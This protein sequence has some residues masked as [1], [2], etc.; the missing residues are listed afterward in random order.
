MTELFRVFLS[1]VVGAAITG[2]FNI[3]LQQ[4]KNQ[5]SNESIY[6]EYSGSLTDRVDKLT[7]E[8]DGLKEQVMKMG[9][10]IDEQSKIIKKQS[11]VID[12]LTSQV[13]NMSNQLKSLEDKY[14]QK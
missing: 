14:E 7:N 5:S 10:Q 2:Y 9:I 4:S 11:K 6:A 3:R 13:E 1:A 8:R 12:G